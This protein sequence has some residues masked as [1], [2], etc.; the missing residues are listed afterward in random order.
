[1]QIWIDK[2]I[3]FS[4]YYSGWHTRSMLTE[5]KIHQNAF[6]LTCRWPITIASYIFCT[7]ILFKYSEAIFKVKN[8]Y[9]HLVSSLM[10]W[11]MYLKCLFFCNNL[12]INYL[13]Q[14]SGIFIKFLHTKN[15]FLEMKVAP[16]FATLITYQISKLVKILNRKFKN[17][18]RKLK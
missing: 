1:M 11:E 8:T 13:F 4:L 18:P 6:W 10:V 3:K 5:H 14:A 2:I 16:Q 7:E 17:V 9:V 12:F 15:Y